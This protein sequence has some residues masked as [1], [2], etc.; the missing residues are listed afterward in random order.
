MLDT[1]RV[2][3][4]HPD[5]ILPKQPRTG[6]VGYDL[7]CIE[8]LRLYPHGTASC[9]LGL[10]LAIPPGHYGR[11][12]PRSGLAD[13]NGIQILGGVLDPGYRG[14]PK[15]ILYNAH[16]TKHFDIAP[17]VK[18]CQLILERCSVFPVVEDETLDE[19]ET[20]RG[21]RGFGSTGL[22]VVS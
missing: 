18:I 5:A 10:R 21:G 8:E 9:R 1:L 12:A 2:R 4:I 6:D 16:P 15:V 13:K 14:A 19:N 11:L 17:G 7:T 20:E 3:R 22:R